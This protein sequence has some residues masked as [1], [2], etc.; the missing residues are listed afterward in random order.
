ME[1]TDLGWSH[2][3][4]S[5]VN[6]VIGKWKRRE[7]L[8]ELGTKKMRFKNRKILKMMITLENNV[9]STSSPVL[10]IKGTR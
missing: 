1:R 7:V 2:H 10:L 6:K 4:L 3:L 8:V 5:E 9:L